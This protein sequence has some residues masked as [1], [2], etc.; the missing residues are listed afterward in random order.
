MGRLPVYH[1]YDFL[2]LST[3][4]ITNCGTVCELVVWINKKKTLGSGF[5]GTVLCFNI[6]NDRSQSGP[7]LDEYDPSLPDSQ[8]NSY[9]NVRICFRPTGVR[10]QLLVSIIRGHPRSELYHSKNYY[11]NFYSPPPQRPG[12]FIIRIRFPL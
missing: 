11:F 2:F 4:Q 7:W 5:R 8:V 12:P 6:A 10:T 3:S 1:P 9:N